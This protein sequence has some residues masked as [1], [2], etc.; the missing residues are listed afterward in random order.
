MT[1]PSIKSI[2]DTVLTTGSL[3]QD[4]QSQIIQQLF[5]HLITPED[6][7]SLEQLEQAYDLGQISYGARKN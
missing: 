1:V 4:Q 3:D 5:S 6:L 7:E 2:I